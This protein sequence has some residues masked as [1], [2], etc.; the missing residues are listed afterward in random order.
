MHGNRLLAAAVFKKFG[1]SQLSQPI[2]SLQ[3]ALDEIAISEICHQVYA[4][5]V[6]AIEAKYKEKILATLFKN[7]TAGKDI[8]ELTVS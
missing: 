1:T 8:Y 3:N 5:L 4:K 7:Q 6:A 2:G